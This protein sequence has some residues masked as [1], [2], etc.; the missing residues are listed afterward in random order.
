MSGSSRNGFTWKDVVDVLRVSQ[1]SDSAILR[2]AI[3]G[4]KKRRIAA[5]RTPVATNGTQRTSEQA[6]LG[7]PGASR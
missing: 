3:K 2:R 1:T 5:K 7:G 6:Q 4:Q